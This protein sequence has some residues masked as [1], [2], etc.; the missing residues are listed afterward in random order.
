[1][2]IAQLIQTLDHL[3]IQVHYRVFTEYTLTGN[4]ERFLCIVNVHHDSSFSKYRALLKEER[5]DGMMLFRGFGIEL[6]P[7]DDEND[8]SNKPKK[9]DMK[10]SLDIVEV[11]EN[12][13]KL[14]LKMKF[15]PYMVR[16][17][18]CR[19]GLPSLQTS[20]AAAFEYYA[21]GQLSKWKVS[22]ASVRKWMPFFQGW[23]RYCSSPQK[24][25]LPPLNDKTY[26]HHYNEFEVMF[27][28]GEFQSSPK[29]ESSFQ[30]LIVVVGPC[31]KNFD[32]L[33]LGLSQEL[34]CSKIVHD[35]NKI[36]EKDVLISMQRSGDRKSVV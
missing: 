4:G 17:L 1:M 20:G 22:G 23:A 32:P 33:A 25:S 14:M 19:D 15:L 29:D 31:K 9:M 11:N 16:T 21:I 28:S 36:T 13:E 12:E 6:V 27:T 5:R 7:T 8:N 35:I 24:T 10:E 34:N 30:G 2:K 18:I 3:K 26:I